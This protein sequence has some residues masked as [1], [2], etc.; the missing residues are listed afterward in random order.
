M[1]ERTLDLH[2]RHVYLLEAGDGPPVLYLHGF[3]DVHGAT[4]SWLPF[5]EQLQRTRRVVAPAHP[6]C[7][8]SDGLQAIDSPEDLVFH[9][10]DVL[11]AL[12]FRQVDV[13]GTCLG[14][15]VAAELAVRYP[16]RVRR[17]ALIGATGLHVPGAPIGD[18]FMLSQAKN[19]GDHSDLR[20]LLFNDS[21][22]PA[23][24]QMFPNGK[25]SLEA[26]ML[27][28]QA[29]TFAG[30]IGWSPPY[31]YNPKL[32][33]RLRRITAPVLVVWGD[34]DRMVPLAHAQAY[35]EGVPNG[36]LEVVEGAGHAVHVEQ[37][38]RVARLLEGFLA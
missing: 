16:E 29:L 32:R 6:G 19:G 8:A 13:A 23:P 28:Y 17:L 30:R 14:G 22:A 24:L 36:R 35:A 11:E 38:D 34:E 31:L 26:E 9:Y 1:S 25:T 21:E 4:A 27:R 33:A 18:L 15:W 3:A 37:A 5:H 7:A 10:L 20:G 2:T 12:G